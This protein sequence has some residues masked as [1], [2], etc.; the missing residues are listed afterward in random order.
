VLDFLATTD[1]SRTAGPPAANEEGDATS[2]AS[3]W[4]TRELAE[5]DWERMEEEDRLGAEF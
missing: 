5:R 2:E 3:E 4:E 1:V